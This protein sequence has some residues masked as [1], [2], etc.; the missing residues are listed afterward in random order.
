MSSWRPVWI[1]ASA[2]A[3]SSASVPLAVKKAFLIFP[4]ARFTSFSARSTMGIVG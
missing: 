1:C 2:T 3:V 4:G